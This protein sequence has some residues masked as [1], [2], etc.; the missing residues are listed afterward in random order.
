MKKILFV[1]E[2]LHLGGAEKSLVTLLNQVDLSG[3]HVEVW[4]NALGGALEAN[5]PAFVTVKKIPRRNP[6][7]LERAFYFLLKHLKAEKNYNS[8]QVIWRAFHRTYLKISEAFDVA[9]AYHQGLPTYY[10]LEK[11]NA[12]RR[13]GWL[14]TDYRAARYNT[15]I[16][17]PVFRKLNR[18]VAVSHYARTTLTESFPYEDFGTKVQVV[19]D[20]IDE[21]QINLLAAAS[22]TIMEQS[23]GIRIVTVGRLNVTKGYGLALEAARILAERGYAF[24]WFIVGEG[25]QREIIEHRIIEYGLTNR[26]FLVGADTNPYRYMRAADIYVQT[27]VLEGFSISVREAKVLNKPIVCTNFPSIQGA[28][29]D[30]ETGLIAQ[31]NGQAIADQIARLID[32]AKLREHLSNNLANRK[33]NQSEGFTDYIRQILNV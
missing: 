2:S 11:I 27:S 31:M 12:Q 18:I 13:I 29:E 23:E 33:Q 28:L 8:S 25:D 30:G 22:A 32:D 20:F 26:V 7:F 6:T 21:G 16:D 10:I 5:L 4:V 15:K 14:N 17:L 24:S 1:I 3:H 19:E 9:V